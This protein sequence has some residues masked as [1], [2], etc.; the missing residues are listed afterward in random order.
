[1]ENNRLTNVNQTWGFCGFISILSHLNSRR[2]LAEIP[3]DHQVVTRMG[4]EVITQLRIMSIE[5]PNLTDE[6]VQFTN[7]FSTLVDTPHFEDIEQVIAFVEARL[8]QF[9]AGQHQ[10]NNFIAGVALPPNAVRSILNRLDLNIEHEGQQ[11]DRLTSVIIGIGS[12]GNPDNINYNN[13]THWIY[14]DPNGNISDNG[15]TRAFNV[16]QNDVMNHHEFEIKHVFQLRE[17][18]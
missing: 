12:T 16:Y 11:L 5:E 13:L 6:I 10:G 8:L 15:T 3:S 17:Q 4:A 2:P 18:N 1:M 14:L 9:D 7:Q